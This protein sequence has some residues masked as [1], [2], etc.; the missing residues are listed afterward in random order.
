M[1]YDIA[2]WY[3]RGN[4]NKIKAFKFNF[5]QRFKFSFTEEQMRIADEYIER[6]GATPTGI[7]RI[8]MKTD[9][10]RIWREKVERV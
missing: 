10:T 1:N 7:G 6:F 5:P 3:Q 9:M 2:A 4:E 8:L